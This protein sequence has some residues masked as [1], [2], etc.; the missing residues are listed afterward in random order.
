VCR[1]FALLSLLT[2]LAGGSVSA[3]HSATGFDGTK[4]LT[5]T[6][7][8]REF[9]WKNPHCY[10]QLVV[11]NPQNKEEE[12]SLEMGAPMYL[13]NQGWRP[14]TL[15]AGSPVTVKVVPLRSGEHGGLVL[16]VTMADGR[17]AGGSRS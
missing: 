17:K 5:L 14:A 1:R 12:W 4:T 9:Q 2:A 3:H 8:V 11:K 13:Y 16:E 6:G 15:K 10:I 7:T